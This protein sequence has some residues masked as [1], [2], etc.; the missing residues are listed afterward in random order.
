MNPSSPR[1]STRPETIALLRARL[2]AP[3]FEARL[4]ELAAPG[5][6]TGSPGP[7]SCPVSL[8]PAHGRPHAP[9]CG[10]GRSS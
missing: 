1:R 7:E 2:S 3:W 6:S 4:R 10:P 9:P 5:V 8:S